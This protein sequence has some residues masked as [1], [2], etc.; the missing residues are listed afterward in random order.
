MLL[1]FITVRNGMPPMYMNVVNGALTKQGEFD[2]S[3]LMFRAIDKLQRA[4][5]SLLPLR[6]I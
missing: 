6:I 1:L 3:S 5:R 2:K 4:I